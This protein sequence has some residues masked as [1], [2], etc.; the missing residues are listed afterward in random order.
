MIAS[1]C[2]PSEPEL[3]FLN[4]MNTERS[5]ARRS[6]PCLPQAGAVRQVSRELPSTRLELAQ[7]D[8]A[9]RSFIGRRR[10]EF[11]DGDLRSAKKSGSD[12]VICRRDALIGPVCRG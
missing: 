11:S 1:S 3:L 8:G 5:I 12:E 2:A 10:I 6:V 7:H 9:L 4:Q